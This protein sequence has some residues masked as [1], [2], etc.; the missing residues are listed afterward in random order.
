MPSAKSCS[1]AGHEVIAPATAIHFRGE[2]RRARERA[3]SDGEGYQPILF[4]VERLGRQLWPN[5]N[6]LWK[7]AC[8]FQG[9]VEEHHPLAGEGA[10]DHE[11]A[12]A[13][14]YDIVREARNDA[15]HIGTANRRES[16]R[17]V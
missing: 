17:S 16:S 3:L 4:A 10:D 6:G 1:R 14:R 9:L 5:K 15:M 12:F 13:Q 8:C 7:F 11:L 2:L